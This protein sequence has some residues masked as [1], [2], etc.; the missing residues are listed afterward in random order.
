MPSIMQKKI[1]DLPA[2]AIVLMILFLGGPGTV[3][4]L[5][6]GILN[7]SQNDPSHVAIE[8]RLTMLEKNMEKI[9]D[10]IDKN[11]GVVAETVVTTKLN[12]ERFA[13]LSRR[14]SEILSEL[15][16]RK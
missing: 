15:R 2:W 6:G 9:V 1:T 7:L 5:S 4:L 10:I 14:L 16:N 12:E 8:Q 3:S 11:N 13:Q